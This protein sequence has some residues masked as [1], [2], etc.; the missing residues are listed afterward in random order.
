MAVV[1]VVA[2]AGLYLWLRPH[3]E[4]VT[5]DPGKIS[6][7]KELVQL[8]A[9]DIYRE[10]P[11]LDTIN[12]KVIFAVQKQQGSISFDI[13]NLNI[14]WEQDTV[15]VTLPKEIV[16]I[17]E[18]TEDNSWEV[19][20]TKHIG[21]LGAIRQDRLTAQEENAVKAKL[22]KRSVEE[23][24]SNGTVARARKEAAS[25][26]EDMLRSLLRKEVRVKGN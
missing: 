3:K 23:L 10:V 24:Y 25:N 22:R 19:I 9:V 6:G 13:E 12:D 26:L 21:F 20:D 7:V 14:D 11:V 2:G 8:C 18:S 4:E 5:V 15:N 16:E 1:A 17:Y